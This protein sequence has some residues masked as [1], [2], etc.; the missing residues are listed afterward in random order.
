MSRACGAQLLTVSS[1]ATHARR[2]PSAGYRLGENSCDQVSQG[3]TEHSQGQR[4]R[5]CGRVIGFQF[6]WQGVNIREWVP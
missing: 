3:S 2:E 1:A 4:Y 5:G 6:H